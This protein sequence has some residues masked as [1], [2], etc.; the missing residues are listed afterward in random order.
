[1]ATLTSYLPQVLPEWLA[2]P[3]T[4][5]I[6]TFTQVADTVRDDAGFAVKE[7]MI[8]E[9]TTDAYPFHLRNSN[10]PV[11]AGEASTQQLSVLRD[12]WNIWRRCG[13]VRGVTDGLARIGLPGCTVTTELDL[14]LAGVPNAFGGYQGFFFVTVPYPNPFSSAAIWDGGLFLGARWD[15]GA[16]WGLKGDLALLADAIAQI[17]K[18]KHVCSSCR[19]IVIALDA[20]FAAIARWGQVNWGQF[21]WGAFAGSYIVIPMWEQWEIGIDGAQERE[22]YNYSYTKERI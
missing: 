3:A 19:F 15:T 20:N 17:R 21:A 22:F 9:A 16:F 14:R 6:T 5:L 8:E 11:I 4:S 7:A 13:T 12:R 1:M 18:W 10:I 2:K